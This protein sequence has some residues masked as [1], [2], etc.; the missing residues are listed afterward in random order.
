MHP[1]F[2]QHQYHR[3]SQCEE[4]ISSRR[5]MHF[6]GETPHEDFR[7]D[8]LDVIV[9]RVLLD[10]LPMKRKLPL[11]QVLDRNIKALLEARAASENE[12]GF[13]HRI[14]THVMKVITSI[15]FLYAHMIFLVVWMVF[16]R[17]VEPLS[18]VASFEGIFLTILV[19]IN[20]RGMSSM[21]ENREDLD[22][23]M[24]LI[25]EHEITRA[26]AV[27]DLLAKKMKVSTV[28]QVPDLEEI[29]STIAPEKV[30]ER[31]VDLKDNQEA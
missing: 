22:L 31:I 3:P 11:N 18:E 17:R 10:I 27:L 7:T 6:R 15:F 9:V 20:Q 16:Y 8:R 5:T 12:R 30:L 28:D 1:K 21:V 23:Q 25:T 14:I 13:H 29:K 26:L 4:V 2:L 24:S 19:L